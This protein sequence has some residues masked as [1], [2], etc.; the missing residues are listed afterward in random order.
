MGRHKSL[1]GELN[2]AE[3]EAHGERVTPSK[4]DILKKTVGRRKRV[5]HLSEVIE[6]II[7]EWGGAELLAKSFRETY[8]S[9]AKG[10]MVRARMLERIMDLMKLNAQ[11]YGSED[12]FDDM[13]E[14]D[15]VAF[16]KAEATGVFQEL[17]GEAKQEGEA[18]GREAEAEAAEGTG[19]AA[20]KGVSGKD[21]TTGETKVAAKDQGPGEPAWHEASQREGD[22]GGG[23][24]VAGV[25]R[26]PTGP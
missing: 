15:L 20:N 6:Q 4:I 1:T 25:P 21:A 8:L 11:M 3:A 12:E 13:A 16:I 26:Q 14:D 5:P 10:S 24:R 17:S 23:G 9:A 2:V 18:D 19:V 7:T 22:R